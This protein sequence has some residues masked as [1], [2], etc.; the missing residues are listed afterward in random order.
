M[1]DKKLLDLENIIEADRRGFY[2]TG[3]AL[4]RIRSEQ[5]YRQL[6][7]DSFEKYVRLRWDM[8]KSHAYRL[9]QACKVIDNL[10]PI[11]DGILP[12]NEYQ[13]RALS[14][15]KTVDQRNIWNQFIASGMHMS[16]VNIR[17]FIKMRQR[18]NIAA[19]EPEKTDLIEVIS[20]DYK[21]AVS[22]MLDQIRL[23]QNDQWQSTSR[24]AALFWLQVMK[25]KIV[26]NLNRSTKQ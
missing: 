19:A 7:Y 15:L 18:K 1:T 26:S 13:A 8:A 16:A 17:R 24:P 4:M 9:I 21:S 20:S 6:F 12:Q 5:L 3:K 11:G 14:S 22:A 10:S 23:A 2:Q 25:Q